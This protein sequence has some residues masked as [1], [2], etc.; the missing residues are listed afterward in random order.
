MHRP[1]MAQD[2]IVFLETIDQRTPLS[3]LTQERTPHTISVWRSVC[4][5]ERTPIAEGRVGA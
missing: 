1:L 5:Q 4:K 2:T 3:P